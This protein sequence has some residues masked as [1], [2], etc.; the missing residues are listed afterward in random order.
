MNYINVMLIIIYLY[1]LKAHSVCVYINFHFIYTIS[2]SLIRNYYY[3][4][5]KCVLCVVLCNDSMIALD[6]RVTGASHTG[7]GGGCTDCRYFRPL[8]RS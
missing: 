2:K 3:F 1:N 5:V 4:A 6:T 7:L 8:C